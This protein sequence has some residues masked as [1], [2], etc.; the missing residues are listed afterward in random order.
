[1]KKIYYIL[2]FVFATGL[3]ASCSNDINGTNDITP[4]EAPSISETR[5]FPQDDGA[6]ALSGQPAEKLL[7]LLH[8]SDSTFSAR[9]ANYE[10]PN[11][12][13]LEEIKAFTDKLVEGAATEAVKANRIYNWVKDSIKYANGYVS[14]EP[15]DVFNNKKAVCQGYANLL[16]LMYHTQGIPVINAY[17]YLMSGG[18][19]LGHAWNYAYYSGIWWLIDATNKL[20][21]RAEKQLDEYKNMFIPLS[22]DGNFL[23]TDQYSYS[24][25]SENL[26]LNKVNYADEAFVIPF[27]VTLTNGEKYQISH[28]NPTTD[29]PSNVKEIYIGKNI[30]S[31]GHDGTYGLKDHAP[32]V[33][34]AHVDPE[35]ERLVSYEGVIYDTYNDA[36]LYIPRGMRVVYLKPTYNGTIGKNF[37]YNEPNIEEVYFPEGTTSM[38]NW[39]VE[40]CP[41]LK[42][43][44]LPLNTEYNEETTFVE[45]HPDFKVVRM[46]MTGIKDV[47]A[48]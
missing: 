10:E 44:Y 38:E 3:F 19:S 5:A 29:L 7:K 14:N 34:A 35:N 1:M 15:Y 37:L 22:V 46:D 40:K 43:A 12:Y 8:G 4:E 6:T 30:I 21:Y 23:E 31:I 26:N 41:N 16:N 48:D 13:Q 27:S 18:Q 25:T 47:I 36:P 39:A 28:F 2:S 11:K 42:V 9:M 17:G 24:Y 20:K 33:E 45:V 32:S